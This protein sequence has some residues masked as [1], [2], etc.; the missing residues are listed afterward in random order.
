VGG[1]PEVAEDV[2][3]RDTAALDLPGGDRGV[4]AA[5]EQRHGSTLDAERQ[6][7]GACDRRA[8]QVGLPLGELDVHGDLGPL[9]IDPGREGAE[10]RTERA[11][12]LVPAQRDALAG[13]HAAGAHRE[14][15]P[16]HGVGE[17]LEPGA[18][19]RVGAQRRAREHG[20]NR[21]EAEDP[22]ERSHVDARRDLG[23]DPRVGD[24]DARLRSRGAQRV[25][26][27]VDEAAHEVL[28]GSPRLQADLAGEAQQR[29]LG[30]GR[31]HARA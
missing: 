10:R 2:V 29:E 22:R 13:A 24:L 26:E 5:G 11:L 15:A 30:S 12:H 16:A 6:A 14:A 31:P 28:P 9:E 4:E 17:K 1:A 23:Q 27:V 7:A 20:R 18:H 21:L 25:A 19:D 3:E 8:E